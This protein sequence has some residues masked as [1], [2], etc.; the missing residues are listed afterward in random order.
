MGT[1]FMQRDDVEE[2]VMKIKNKL[3]KLGPTDKTKT[4]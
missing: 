2:A 3:A 4:V 1:Y